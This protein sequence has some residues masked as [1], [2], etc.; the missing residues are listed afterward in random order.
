MGRAVSPEGLYTKMY[1][2]NDKIA[3]IHTLGNGWKDPI[4][5][6]SRCLFIKFIFPRDT[7]FDTYGRQL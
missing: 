7:E 1:P 5:M 4:D 6:F 3:N 2:C